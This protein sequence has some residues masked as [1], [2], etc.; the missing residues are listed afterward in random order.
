[1][2][3]I[4]LDDLINEIK[5]YNTNQD[6]IDLII[7]AYNYASFYHDGQKRDSG[8]D[9]IIHP[10]N[11][12]FI[13]SEMHADTDTLC[14][15]LLHDTLE[16]TKSTKQDIAHEFN[17]EIAEL[18]DGVTNIKDLEFSSNDDV[19]N[20]NMRKIITS[21]TKDVRIILIKLADRLHNMRTLNYKK[22]NKQRSKSIETLDIYVPFA[23]YLGAY[24]LKCELEDLAFMYLKPS[25]FEI[26]KQQR[27]NIQ[28]QYMPLVEEMSYKVSRILNDK[29]IPYDIRIRVKNVYGIY[30]KLSEGK[31]LVDIHDLLAL[32]IIVDDIDNCYVTLGAVHSV[33]KPLNDKFRD[34]ICS[35]KTNMYQSL[36]TTVYSGDRFIHTQIRT[37]D[38]DKIASFGFPAFWDIKGDTRAVMQKEISDKCQFFTSLK[39]IDSIFSNNT[40]FVNSIKSEVFSDKV[41]VYDTLGNVSELP[42]GSTIIDYAYRISGS[43]AEK[44]VGALVN[45]KNV[46]LNYVLQ[47]KDRIKLIIDK[48][49]KG[50]GSDW[51]Q[52]AHTSYAKS[53]I[54]KNKP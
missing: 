26:L 22:V 2:N 16:D 50:P 4:C 7:K 23:Y 3:N 37:H 36:H 43:E 27:I 34:Y 13:L 40:E 44:L 35:P 21:V 39:E 5:K 46:S 31:R 52:I 32:K 8:E 45:D 33:Y 42:K 15:G 14:A 12:A 51:S 53:L 10:L 30:Q 28:D 24:R 1:M 11:V 25:E 20:A 41:Y 17:N 49:A 19:Y 48:L 18:V 6:D 29:G 54:L 38:M 9:Y 47:N